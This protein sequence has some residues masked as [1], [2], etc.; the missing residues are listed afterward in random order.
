MVP[1]KID[2]ISITNVSVKGMESIVDWFEQHLHSFFA[3]GWSYLKSQQQMEELFFRTIIKAHKEMRQMKNET[4]FEMWVT[5]IFIHTCQELSDNSS[6][7]DSGDSE[8]RQDLFKALDQLNGYEKD[9]MVLTYIKGIPNEEVAQ[10][11]QISVEKLKEHLVSGIQSLRNVMG[12]GSSFNGCE[13]YHMSYLDYLERTM[14]RPKKIDLEKHIFH[15]Q[16]CQE[17]LAAFQDVMLTML[18]LTERLEGFHVP[19]GFMENVVNRLAEVEKHRQQKN[20]KRKRMGLVFASIFAL[21]MGIEYFTGAFASLYYSWTEKDPELSRYLQQGLGERMNLEAES[22]GVKIKIKGA[23]ADDVQ[24]IVFYEIEDTDGDNQYVMNSQDGVL[25]ENAYE[26]MSREAN[27]REYP[28]NHE[29]AVNNEKKNVYHGKMSLLP[30][31][32][33]NGTI[34]LK[35]TKVQKLIRDSSD[36]NS[37]RAYENMEYETGEW[38]F[39]IPV[40]KQPSAEYALDEKTEVEG[41]PIRFDKLTIAPTAT[42]LQY[43]I[44]NDESEKWIDNLNFDYLEVNNK[45]A[46][47]DLYGRSYLDTKQEMNW[48]TFQTNFDPLFGEKPKAVSVKFGAIHLT[49]QDPK[50]IELNA[51]QEYPQTFEYA[52]STI[53]I[54]RVEIGQPT[55]IVISNYEVENRAYESL[56][57]NIIGED[58][59]EPSSM[60]MSSEGVLVDKNG[61]E[62]KEDM[63]ASYEDI[64]QPRYFVTVE[65]MKV[66]GNNTGEKIIPKRLE[67][68]GYNITKYLDDIV[69]ISLK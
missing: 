35:I 59:N 21:L 25:V 7:Q 26:I 6:L 42:I 52:G 28:L 36:L 64:E 61:E 22:N 23:I 32:K 39:K 3:L 18:N 1:A 29:S 67:I 11:L 62:Y 56:Q 33:K 48:S 34:K 55:K 58:E 24:T 13:E 30:L 63:A 14:D 47:A 51:T 2:T 65:S 44:P 40:I 15:C 38:N 5:S 46:K 41:I 57:Y 12:Y 8:P 69:K 45:K 19:S 68:Y 60:E 17:D 31:S 54:D 50:T 20:K 37:I 9:V 27:L 66:E 43:S 4:S 10:L 49:I 16:N 53:S